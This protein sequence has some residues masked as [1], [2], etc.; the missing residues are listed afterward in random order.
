[1]EYGPVKNFDPP[2][3]TVPDIEPGTEV[4][5]KFYKAGD[6]SVHEAMD[7]GMIQAFVQDMQ[8]RK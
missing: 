7:A 4:A 1:M 8:K 6:P 5:V 2:T 3:T